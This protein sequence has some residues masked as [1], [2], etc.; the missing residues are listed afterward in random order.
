MR[1]RKGFADPP[2]AWWACVRGGGTQEVIPLKWDALRTPAF[3]FH[4]LGPFLFPEASLASSPVPWV[5]SVLP[6]WLD[7]GRGASFPTVRSLKIERPR[8]R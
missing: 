3:R 7:S 8:S 2:R 5:S 6:S 1:V 4:A